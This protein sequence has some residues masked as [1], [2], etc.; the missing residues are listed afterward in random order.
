[1]TPSVLIQNL[2]ALHVRLWLDEGQLRYKAPKGAITPEIL[3]QLKAHKAAIIEYLTDRTQSDAQSGLGPK[4]IAAFT[5]PL[6]FNQRGLWFIHELAPESDFG[7]NIPEALDLVGTLDESALERALQC[8]INRHQALRTRFIKAEQENDEEIVLQEILPEALLPHSIENLEGCS[9]ADIAKRIDLE[10]QRT[11][12]LSTAPLLRSCLFKLGGQHAIL[13]I[14]LHHIIA[15]GWSKGLL[16]RELALAYQHYL[17]TGNSHHTDL[18]TGLTPDVDQYP[19]YATW[20]QNVYRTQELPNHV[21][22]WKSRLLEAPELLEVMHDYPRPQQRKYNGESYFSTLDADLSR[23]LSE[24]AR[25]QGCSTFMLLFSA[26]NILLYR[27]SGCRDL[28][29]GTQTANR[30]TTAVEKTVGFFVNTLALRTQIQENIT[31]S[32][33]LQQVKTSVLSDFEHQSMPFDQLIEQL[34][35]ERHS[36]YEPLTQ[37]MFLMQNVP[38][39][40]LSLPGLSIQ[41]RM[42]RRQSA[43]FDLTLIMSM[44]GNQFQCEFEYSTELYKAETIVRLNEYFLNILKE[45]LEQPDILLSAIKMMPDKE[46]E[47]I[48]QFQSRTIDTGCSADQSPV[49]SQSLV[50]RFGQ[51]ANNSPQAIAVADTVR[52]YS[53]AQLDTLATRCASKLRQIRVDLQTNYVGICVQRSNDLIIAILGVLKA[54][55]A[56][57]PLDSKH[58][59]ARLMSQVN[60]AK[61]KYLITDEHLASALTP[62]VSKYRDQ[63]LKSVERFQSD[64]RNPNATLELLHLSSLTSEPLVGEEP[65]AG[66]KP[67]TSV[68]ECNG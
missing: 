56:Y 41:P 64:K 46:I 44:E 7:Y 26:F 38:M 48:K 4:S 67:S 63:H 57:V 30:H 55:M 60:D 40:N 42:I 45:V 6:S 29:V 37:V 50:D 27:L 52:H 54:G 49:A 5:A 61:I 47:R 59:P 36:T 23:A 2:E 9:D 20:Q 39:G 62:L 65:L 31:F 35:P 68:L 24:E 34:S 53:Y 28:I 16:T 17:E 13:V 12:D 3:G 21:G 10:I 33:L 25:K 8:L 15:D 22:Y 19:D 43:K 14:T 1:M 66:E 58:P 32:E 18:V 11:F 51:I